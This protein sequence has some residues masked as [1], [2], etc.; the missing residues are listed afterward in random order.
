MKKSERLLDAI[1][2]IDD[3][4][5]EEAALAGKQPEDI[6]MA[7]KDSG[8]CDGSAP[9]KTGVS[10]RTGK[11]GKKKTAVFRWQG[12][13][14]ACA[15][16]AVCIS[17]FALLQK[18]GLLLSPF[19]G[20]SEAPEMA[21]EDLD[22]DAAPEAAPASAPEA[23]MQNAAG[24]DGVAE[25]SAAGEAAGQDAGEA[26][27][28]GD[29][30]EAAQPADA[31]EKERQAAGADTPEAQAEAL[32][33]APQG[34]MASDVSEEIITV[35]AAEYRAGTVTFTLENKNADAVFTYGQA[36]DLEQLTEGIWQEVP[37][38][39]EAVWKDIGYALKAGEPAEVT[40]KVDSLYGE[41]PAGEYRLVK[42][43]SVEKDGS[44]QHDLFYVEFSVAE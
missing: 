11:G 23:A 17:V 26:G 42:K 13:L 40:V 31:L 18:S 38:R 34:R 5:V 36:Y 32:G 39:K 30:E 44:V 2:Q 43:C 21:A 15:V 4:Y 6:R 35:T 3:K 25:E 41:L 16:L 7:G 19:E 33:I 10:E 12:A 14:A 27:T 24:N 9:S 1:G 8:N 29:A 22:M 20:K 37:P 28:T